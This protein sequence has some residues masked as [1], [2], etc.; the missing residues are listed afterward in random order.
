MA[1]GIVMRRCLSILILLFITNAGI[2]APVFK[3]TSIGVYGGLT[4]SNLSA[5]LLKPIGEDKY[6]MLDA[7]SLVTGLQRAVG[8]HAIEDDVKNLLQNQI[9]TYLISHAHLDH[10]IGLLMA[11]PELREHQTIMARSETMDTLKKY[12]FNWSVWGNFG[13]SGEYPQLNFQHYENLPLLQWVSIPKTEMQVKTFPLSH[14]KDMPSTAFLI[15]YKENYVLYFG[16]TGADKIEN[17]SNMRQIWLEVATLIRHKQLHAIMLECSFANIQPSNKLFGHLKPELF[18]NEL[19]QLAEIVDPLNPNE[20]LTGLNVVVT[21][22]KPS[23]D[24]LSD[25]KQD[26]R[27]SVFNELKELNNL[28]LNLLL[29]Q[30]GKTLEI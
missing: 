28:G 10:I 19:Y 2:A 30:Q 27:Q 13:D 26:P 6:V 14:G 1:K 15:K 21:H 23:L 18:M 25:N 24:K 17:S 12:I 8:N 9:S 3:L 11:Q 5:Y 22:I 7:G 29:P 16:D 4:D 20:S